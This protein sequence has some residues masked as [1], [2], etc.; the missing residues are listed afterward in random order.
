MPMT[1][2]NIRQHYE[3]AWKTKSDGAADVSQI[4]YS[5][6]VEDAIVYPLYRQMVADLKLR[7]SGGSVLDIGAGSGRWIRFFLQNF[8]PRELVGADY[9]L[10]SVELLRK[11]F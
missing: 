6:P 8:T 4:A 5:S 11:W 2:E 10:A 3:G 9:T 7:V 1:Q